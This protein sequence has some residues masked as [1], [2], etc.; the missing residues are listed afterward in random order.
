M[1][2]FSFGTFSQVVELLAER[3]NLNALLLDRRLLSSI[4]ARASLLP[5]S[6][7]LLR[8]ADRHVE[9]GDLVGVLAW[10][11]HLDRA[12]PVEVEVAQR[13]GQRLQ[14]NLLQRGLV[15]GH[16]EMRG[17]HATLVGS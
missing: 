1:R 6:V 17:Q 10:S 7:P 3:F 15:Q 4:D 9:V 11:R 16:V 2:A 8:H 14:L 13:V 12:R 5:R